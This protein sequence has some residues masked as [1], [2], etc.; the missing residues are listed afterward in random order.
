MGRNKKEALVFTSIMCFFMVLVMSFYNMVLVD[1]WSASLVS[2][3]MA[4]FLPALAVALVLDIFVVSKVAKGLAGRLLR[5]ADPFVKKILLISLFMVIGMAGCMSLFG[6]FMHYGFTG[7]AFRHY[8]PTYGL[9]FLFALP[10]QLAVVGPLTRFI[11]TRIYPAP[12]AAPHSQ[13]TV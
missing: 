12:A 4:G 1:G 3:A 10:L 11:F 9:N 6:T 13:Q 8:L 2:R 5:P 7:E